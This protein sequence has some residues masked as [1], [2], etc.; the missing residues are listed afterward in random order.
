MENRYATILLVITVYSYIELQ[1]HKNNT[2][3]NV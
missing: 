2:Q 1:K 3:E